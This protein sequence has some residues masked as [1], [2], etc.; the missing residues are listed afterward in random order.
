MYW[1]A[2]PSLAAEAPEIAPLQCLVLMPMLAGYERIREV[3]RRVVSAGGASMCR[4]EEALPDPEWQRWLVD[5]VRTAHFVVADVTDH[6]AFV[7]YELGL[8]HSR[9]L[10]GLLIVDSRN[11]RVSATVLGSPFL[12]YDTS[13]LASFEKDLS[14]LVASKVAEV[15][16][17]RPATQAHDPTYRD[18]YQQALWLFHQF[19][20]NTSLDIRPVSAEEFA[21]R[22]AVAA[23]R[24]ERIRTGVERLEDAWC[25]MPRIVRDSDQVKRMQTIWNWMKSICLPT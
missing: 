21:V 19:R 14:T 22:L 24:G 18:L 11:E 10:P 4:L 1:Q 20:V 17:A 12:P 6:N 8:A 15:P 5:S 16:S 2:S 3:V 23:G 7:M 13:D 25:L 9:G